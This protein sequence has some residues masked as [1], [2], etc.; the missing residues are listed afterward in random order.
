[1][2]TVKELKVELARFKDSDTCFAYEGEVTG[3]IVERE[4]YTGQGV[5]YCSE[6]DDTGKHTD[7]ID[8]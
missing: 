7:I 5:I 2:R 6:R 1:M 8:V 3:I 4:G